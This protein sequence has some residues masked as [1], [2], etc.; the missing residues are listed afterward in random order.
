MKKS[1]LVNYYDIPYQGG[2]SKA[3]VTLGDTV[4]WFPQ[5]QT[6][7]VPVVAT[8]IRLGDDMLTLR[9]AHDSGSTFRTITG[10]V[11]IGDKRL[12]NQNVRKNGAWSTRALW[13]LIQ[14]T[15]E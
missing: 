3:E 10:V 6:Q 1:D 15:G 11:A 14:F 9:L 4:W 2:V 12:T 7:N 8:V 13:D 5:G